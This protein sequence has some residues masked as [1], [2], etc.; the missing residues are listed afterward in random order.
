MVSLSPAT[1]TSLRDIGI[2]CGWERH[3]AAMAFQIPLYSRQ[4]AAPTEGQ[5]PILDQTQGSHNTIYRG[6]LIEAVLY[7]VV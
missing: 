5:L 1:I 2:S 7:V 3:L 4:D 6:L